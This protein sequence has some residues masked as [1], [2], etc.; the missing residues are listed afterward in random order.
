MVR[1]PGLRIDVRVD[2]LMDERY[3]ALGDIAGYNRH[4][5]LGRMFALWA[6]CLDRQE[7]T[8]HEAIVRRFLGPRGV[9]AI[10]GEVVPGE[11]VD[12]LALGERRDGGIFVRG[13]ESLAWLGERRAAAAKGGEERAHGVR[14]GGGRFVTKQTSTPA[15]RHP[16]SSQPATQTPPNIQPSDL[17]SDPDP[18]PEE[19][20]RE[21]ARPSAAPVLA[22]VP[23]TPKRKRVPRPVACTDAERSSV[24]VVLAKLSEQSGVTWTFCDTHAKLILARLR[25]GVTEWDLRIVIGYCASAKSAGGLGWRDDEKMA[26]YLR[27]A[28][29]FGPEKI[30]DYLPQARAWY[31]RY[32]DD[33][34]KGA[35]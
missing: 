26:A 34:R 3:E 14:D 11:I 17:L 9:E 19:R 6:W 28:T 21:S 20:E 2:V 18:D 33:K 10:L 7:F 25:A 24:E 1:K 16:T 31:E 8:L 4:E 32:V 22:L 12:S 13:S 23:P 27:P 5:A 15:K 35:S 30:H 29:L